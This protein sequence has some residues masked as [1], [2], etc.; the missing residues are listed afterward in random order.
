MVSFGLSILYYISYTFVNALEG[1]WYGTIKSMPQEIEKER[2]KKL[3]EAEREGEERATERR[4]G[5][6]KLPYRRLTPADID[7][8]NLYAIPRDEAE[9]ARV[10]VVDREKQ[11]ITVGLTDPKNLETKEILERLERQGFKVERVLVSASSM[12][13]ALKEYEKVKPPAKPRESGAIT[14][15]KEAE[16]KTFRDLEPR[17]EKMDRAEASELLE[18]LV[19]A[20]LALAA[21]DVHIEPGENETLIRLRLDGML[22]PAGSV[23]RDVYRL[24]V[25]RVKLL[26]G[27]QLNITSVPQ[28]GRFSIKRPGH[29][30]TEIRVSVLPGAHGEF[31]ALRLLDPEAALIKVDKL[32]L[33]DELWAKIRPE[34]DKPNGIIL[35]TGPTG[36]GKTTTLYAFVKYLL[37]PE[38]KIIT[39]E[40]P[41]E[42]HLEG[43][44]QSQ[45][46]TGRGYTFAE[47]MKNA[48]RQDPDV[49]LVGEIRDEET[50]QT[51]LNAALT[52]HLVFST[53]HT[54]D[55]PGAVPRF[56]DLNAK[57]EILASALNAVIAQRLV[58]KL[59]KAC[60]EKAEVDEA[61]FK[62]IKEGLKY[63]ADLQKKLRREELTIYE[64]VGC[65][66]CSGTG[67]RGRTG[68]FEVFVIDKTMEAV[69]G[70][71]PAHREV[72]EAA[73][74]A[75]FVDMY[76]DGL[77]RVLEGITTLEEVERVALALG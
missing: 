18:L 9:R 76:H 61:L 33:R 55:A 71:S 70:G 16:I 50:A 5:E 58:R 13:R 12:A 48:L 62:K 59:C 64:A 20:G 39:L 6:L 7:R 75:G 19:G 42:Y 4:A 37:K 29:E 28:N 32:G 30:E 60:K 22:Q 25:S 49:M 14:L 68:I 66:V 56:L 15:K 44:S 40:D 63:D 17:I 26:A 77:L 52:G 67:Y 38:V 34:I 1:R 74:K 3:A 11:S 53:L 46:D 41:I 72:L 35:V 24:L 36:S 43:L 65:E 21:S 31:I 23:S 69:V 47:A 51:A 8:E 73:R 45:V 57:P 10:V 2:E 54:N 27:V